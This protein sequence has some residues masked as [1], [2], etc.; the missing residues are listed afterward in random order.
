MQ[1]NEQAL[2]GTQGELIIVPAIS[3][4]GNQILVLI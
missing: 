4:D 1:K 2:V 3:T